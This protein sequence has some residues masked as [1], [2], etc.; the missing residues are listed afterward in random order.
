MDIIALNET[1]EGAL[2]IISEELDMGF[3]AFGAC[4]GKFGNG[5]LS[6]FPILSSKNHVL[7]V[8]SGKSKNHF[9]P[10]APRNMQDLF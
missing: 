2:K 9:R 4:H 3:L 1:Y 7:K 8:T 6:N 5:V 10:E